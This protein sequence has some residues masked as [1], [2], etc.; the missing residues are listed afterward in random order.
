MKGYLL[1]RVGHDLFG[2]PIEH[3]VEVID[4]AETEPVPG[5]RRPVRGVA[6]WRGGAVPVIHLGALLSNGTPPRERSSTVVVTRCPERPVAFEVT[7]ADAVVREVARPV[8]P[9]GN[10]PWASGIASHGDQLVPILD[11][12]TLGERLVLESGDAAS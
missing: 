4:D 12:E 6:H 5:A 10:M 1:V 8:P 2:L 11:M 3:V 7:D 9:G